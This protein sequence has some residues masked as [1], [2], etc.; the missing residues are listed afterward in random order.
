M[1]IIS[2]LPGWPCSLSSCVWQKR[3]EFK[4]LS[5][6][7][8]FNCLMDHRGLIALN[9]TA[10]SRH[11]LSRSKQDS[12]FWF[13]ASM[14]CVLCWCLIGAGHRL[15]LGQVS[16]PSRLCLFSEHRHCIPEMPGSGRRHQTRWSGLLVHTSRQ[17]IVLTAPLTPPTTG[18]TSLSSIQA[19][20]P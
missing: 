7:C 8:L 6:C 3:S 11:H 18:I 16:D 17:R 9:K 1:E 19:K 4:I 13:Y 15:S 10:P 2:H 20:L 5:H 12:K 14:S